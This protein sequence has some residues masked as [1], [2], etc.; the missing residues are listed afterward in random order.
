VYVGC[1]DVQKMCDI[2]A[3]REAQEKATH[4]PRNRGYAAMLESKDTYQECLKA[5]FPGLPSARDTAVAILQ[6]A[7]KVISAAQ[8]PAKR[9]LSTAGMVDDPKQVMPLPCQQTYR[10]HTCGILTCFTC[11]K[12]CHKCVACC[13]NS[14]YFLSQH[15]LFRELMMSGRTRSVLL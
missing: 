8:S 6:E 7:N 4:R 2:L 3:E 14:G 1:A 12:F 5:A 10:C 15:S 13:V 11:A 9:L